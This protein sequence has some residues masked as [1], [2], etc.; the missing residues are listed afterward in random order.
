VKSSLIILTFNEIQGIKAL[1]EKIPF[2]QFNECFAVDAGSRDGTLD[3][4]K[5]K[6]IKVILQEKKGRGEAFRLASEKATGDILVFFS[7]DGNEN[8]ADAIKLKKAIEDGYDMAIASRFMKGGESE[9]AGFLFAHRDWG[10]KFFTFWANLFFRGNLSDSINGFRAV[11]KDKFKELKVTAEGFAI[12][13]QMSIRALK[14]NQKIKEIPTIEGQ[15]IGGK[16]TAKSIPTGLKLLRI[17][18]KEIFL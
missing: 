3:F 5:E 14:L 18:L 2:N 16:S 11:R 1:F 15:R 12:E 6:G 8:P 10:N 9:Q 13:Y 17:L 4:L 7:P